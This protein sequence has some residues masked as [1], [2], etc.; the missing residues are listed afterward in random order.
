MNRLGHQAE[1]SVKELIADTNGIPDKDGL[2]YRGR[3]DA[4]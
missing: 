3:T 4:P 1:R 2:K